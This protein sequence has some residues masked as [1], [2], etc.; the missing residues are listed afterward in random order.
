MR[1]ELFKKTKKKIGGDIKNYS[2]AKRLREMGVE[3]TVQAIDQ[4]DKTPA[5]SMRL[6]ALCG[7][8]RMSGMEWQDFGKWL[9]EEFLKGKK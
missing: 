2:I 4:Y 6:D 9:D 3:I 1:V 5:K 8:R 7:L